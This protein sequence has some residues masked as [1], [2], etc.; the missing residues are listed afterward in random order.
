[1]TNYTGL[2]RIDQLFDRAKETVNDSGN[3][4]RHLKSPLSQ[5]ICFSE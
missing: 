1:M 5:K 3:R 2:R 4:V